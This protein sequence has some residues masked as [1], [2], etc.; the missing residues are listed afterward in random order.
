MKLFIV[1][2]K[3]GKYLRNKGFDGKNPIKSTNWV[4]KIEDAKIYTKIGTAKGRVTFFYNNYPKFGCPVLLEFDL[5]KM[6]P[7]VIDL[8]KETSK[9]IAKI[10]KKQAENEAAYKEYMIRHKQSEIARLEANL[11]KLKGE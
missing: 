2:N 5:G 6:A 4:D 8:E 9:K 11:K 3:K 1:Q 7:T 10:K